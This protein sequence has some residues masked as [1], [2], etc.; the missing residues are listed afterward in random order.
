[1]GL[2]RLGTRRSPV[3]SRAAK[4]GVVVVALFAL[5]IFVLSRGDEPT[6]R[7][8]VVMVGDSFAQQSADQFLAFARGE[9]LRSE[10]YA[11]GG[12]AICSW[13]STLA[14]LV[15]RKP[16]R[17]VLSFAGNDLATCINPDQIPARRP[18][19]VADLY[20]DEL[21]SVVRQFRDAGSEIIL[22][23]PPPVKDPLFE[24][25]AA[26]MRDMYAAYQDDHPEVV[27]V[28]TFAGLGPDGEYHKA[29]PCEEGE[30]CR[31]D[32]TV[33]LRQDDDIH[34]TPEGGKRYAQM[35]MDALEDEPG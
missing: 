5:A 17:L 9:G 11:L 30:P 28:E 16:E 21:D 13:E 18:Q 14:D 4:A 33:V 15:E 3:L 34:L 31:P 2:A 6:D 26:A 23:E 12:T 19:T 32:G 27:T 1:M 35:I 25:Y 24:G 20:R 10:V 22:V 7:P 29:L 8:D